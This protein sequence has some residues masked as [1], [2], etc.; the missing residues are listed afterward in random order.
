MQNF[1]KHKTSKAAKNLRRF[2]I[3]AVKDDWDIGR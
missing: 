3:N 1:S 2:G